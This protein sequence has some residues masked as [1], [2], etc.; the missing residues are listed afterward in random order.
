MREYNEVV[1]P[2][3]AMRPVLV[4]E[5]SIPSLW[6]AGRE[7]VAVIG[8]ESQVTEFYYLRTDDRQRFGDGFRGGFG[9]GFQDRFE[10]RAVSARIGVLY[11]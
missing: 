7:P 4:Q 1:A 8:Y 6:R 10:R 2:A 11:R 5:D 3:L 9:G